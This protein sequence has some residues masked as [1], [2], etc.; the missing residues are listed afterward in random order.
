VIG[1]NEA[2]EQSRLSEPQ[3][4]TVPE[5][6]LERIFSPSGLLRKR[7]AMEFRP[8]QADMAERTQ[9]AF[10]NGEA[11]FYEAGTGVGKS[12]AY[13]I[14]GLLMAQ[15]TKRPFIV[16]T[17]TIALQ[18]QIESKDLPLCRKLF[19]ADPALEPFAGFSHAVLMGRANYVCGTRLKS[20]LEHKTELFPSAEQDELR[21]IAE[22]ASQSANGLRSELQPPPLPEV[23]DWVHADNSACN[24]RN[25]SPDTCSLQRAR[26]AVRSANL[27]IVNHSLLFALLA[28]GH[29]P[30]RT[31]PGVL[32]P[33]DFLCLD[34]AHTLP[35]VVTEYFG[36]RLSRAGLKRLLQ[37]AFQPGKRGGRGLLAAKSAPFALRRLVMQAEKASE[38]FFGSI[39][40]AYLK[41]KSILRLQQPD[42]SDNPLNLPLRDLTHGLGQYANQLPEGSRRDEV[43]GL[44]K[45]FQAV[46]DQIMEALNLA[47]E[48]SVYWLE[49]SGPLEGGNV[50]LRSAPLDISGPLRERLFQ[51]QT[52]VL[53]TS[54]T[55]AEGPTMDSFKARLGAR[56][57]ASIIA[58]SPFD[59]PLQMEIRIAA[60]A[61]LPD[62]K[63]KHLNWSFHAAAIRQQLSDLDG[64][65]LVLFT[66]YRDLNGVFQHLAKQWP[67]P[68]RPLLRQGD[69][70]STRKVLL[71][72]MRECGN[73]VLLGTDSFWTGVDIPGPA[74][75]QVIITRLPFENP[76]HPVAEARAEKCRQ[77]G[78]SPFQHITLPAALCKFRQG[79]GRL[80]RSATDEGRLLILDSR[81][82]SKPYG[83]HFLEVLPHDGYK[84]ILCAK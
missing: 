68:E 77:E 13:L 65:C 52:A 57:A 20:A 6:A 53:L 1:F 15:A 82:F 32:F 3:G 37:R 33:D 60:D 69:G 29:F 64:G 48:G 67:Y 55:L 28:A 41:E 9:T 36:L 83:A 5:A 73:A 61:P 7:F 8:Q 31:V 27:V 74:L 66:S 47:Q 80:I 4:L 79:C 30:G 19:A 25:C 75:S 24:P 26:E 34:E 22:W 40:A 71:Q 72:Q 44:R 76:S 10:E 59:Y 23:W 38:N 11:L 43:E 70:H 84:R 18:E 46:R 56:E 50:A 49:R 45:T 42:W 58:A 2:F 35:D 14:P 63:G 21:R 81:C 51:R 78:L 17:Q 54:A 12:L 39:E 16:S 62:E